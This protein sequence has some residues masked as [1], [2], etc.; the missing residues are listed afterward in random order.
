MDRRGQFLFPA[1]VE[2]RVQVNRT[3]KP[4]ACTQ[5]RGRSIR[6]CVTCNIAIGNFGRRL[7][8][9]AKKLHAKIGRLPALDQEL[10]DPG[11]FL[12]T[13]MPDVTHKVIP[14]VK[15]RQG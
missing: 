3:V 8:S 15:P 4:E 1:S 13:N 2:G 12:E 7:T 9:D 14:W 5:L 10:R 6:L 11:G